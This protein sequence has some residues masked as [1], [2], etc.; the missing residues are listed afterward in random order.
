MPAINLFYLYLCIVGFGFTNTSG[1]VEAYH[2]ALRQVDSLATMGTTK[3]L[4]WSDHL[5]NTQDMYTE[6]IDGTLR[7]KKDFMQNDGYLQHLLL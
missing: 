4:P 2:Q 1:E 5:T 7:G 3:D 6:Q